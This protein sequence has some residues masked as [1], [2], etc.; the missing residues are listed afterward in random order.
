MAEQFVFAR[1][2]LDRGQLCT[3]FV[4]GK[5][6]TSDSTGAP[7]TTCRRRISSRDFRSRTCFARRGLPAALA[8]IVR[9]NWRRSLDLKEFKKIDAAFGG[10]LDAGGAPRAVDRF[11]AVLKKLPSAAPDLS[12]AREIANRVAQPEKLATFA[13]KIRGNDRPFVDSLASLL[14]HGA[15]PQIRKEMTRWRTRKIGP[16][17]DFLSETSFPPHMSLIQALN[18]SALRR[19]T[20]QK[21]VAIVTTVRDEGISILEW[22][23]FYRAIGV[24]DFFVYANDNSDG[25]DALLAAL[26]KNRIIKL[27]ESTL[28][29]GTNPQTKAY[30]HAL[31]LLHDLRQFKWVMFLDA[32]EFLLLDP[33]FGDSIELF[34]NHVESKFPADPPGAVVFPWDWRLSDCRYRRTKGL[35]FDRYPHS[36]PHHHVK[37]LMRFQAAL[38]MCQ[39]HIPV[40]DMGSKLVDSDL[41][42]LTE[43]EVWGSEPKSSAGGKIAHFWGK[44]F[45][46]FAVKKRKGDILS[47]EGKNFYRDFSQYFEWNDAQTTNNFHP[48]PRQLVNRTR[49][50]VTQ[51]LAGPGVE[52]IAMDIEARFE[53][54]S[55]ELAQEMDLKRVYRKLSATVRPWM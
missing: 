44:S 4:V 54:L 11:C 53:I 2:I 10:V 16:K 48:A 15:R 27:I 52:R 40:L 42:P 47:L 17:L 9:S 35:L 13:L 39:I 21:R 33:R 49:L 20:P 1:F 8:F 30:Q 38:G 51:L 29:E 36:V 55:D 3:V 19:I 22:L 43:A 31:H 32:D 26:A 18:L 23:A 28:Q 6:E 37:S 34:I 12:A 46:E 45:Q 50:E 41:H 24:T 5:L 14:H 7:S 25:S